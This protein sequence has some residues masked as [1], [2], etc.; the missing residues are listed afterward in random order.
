M[1]CLSSQSHPG[2]VGVGSMSLSHLIN[3]TTAALRRGP[4]TETTS[5]VGTWTHRVSLTQGL[6]A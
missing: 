3:D 6:V 4:G 5:K 2:G 1:C